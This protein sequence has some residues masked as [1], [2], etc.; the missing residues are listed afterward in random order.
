MSFPDYA[1]IEEPLLCYIYLHG[2]AERQI[3]CGRTY[4]PLARFFNLT[5]HDLSVPVSH[6]DDNLKWNNMV[7]WARNSLRKKMYLAPSRHGVWKL[8][9]SGVF[10]A[11]RLIAK[12]ERLRLL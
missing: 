9:E 5:E 4:R 2:G 1:S 11:Q 12:H 10:A 8:S 7:R 6:E 3:E